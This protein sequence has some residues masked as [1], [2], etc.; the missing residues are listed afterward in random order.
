MKATIKF[1]VNQYI[2]PPIPWAET[3]LPDGWVIGVCG[4]TWEEARNNLLDRL[5]AVSL[6]SPPPPDEVVEI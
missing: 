3:I 6:L 2:N 4:K 5:R 1:S